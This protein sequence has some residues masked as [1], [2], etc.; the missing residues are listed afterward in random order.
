MD[1]ITAINEELSRLHHTY[2]EMLEHP[3]RVLGDV[4]HSDLLHQI[5]CLQKQLLAE[6]SVNKFEVFCREWA[7]GCLVASGTAFSWSGS[8]YPWGCKECTHAFLE[9]V[10]KLCTIKE[11]KP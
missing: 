5:I 8:E 10:Y 11:T 6:P 1:K 2:V 4:L 9:V 7:R 3:D